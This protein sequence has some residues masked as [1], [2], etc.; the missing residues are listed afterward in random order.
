MNGAAPH[1]AAAGL[2]LGV[3]SRVEEITTGV[4]VGIS[5]NA[6][7]LAVAFACGLPHGRALT[8]A[9]AGALAL[10]AAN[11]GYYAWIVVLEPGVDPAAVA[12]PPA[13][14]FVL[15]ATGGALLGACGRGWRT[16][17]PRLRFAAAFALSGVLVADG[18][19]A[20]TEGQATDAP[21]LI[22]G[23]ALALH[24]SP[25]GAARTPALLALTTLVAVAATGCLEPLLP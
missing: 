2:V 8:A 3:L 18:A 4:S 16:G 20:L 15:G 10:T 25:D 5:S 23:I 21:G 7:W 13:R 6:A 12:G 14:W 19:T 11:G 22:A 1:C 17:G 24:A 9:G